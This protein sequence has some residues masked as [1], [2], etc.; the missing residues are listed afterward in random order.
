MNYSML[1]LVLAYE[2]L[3]I[4][5]VGAFL[6]WRQSK[7]A[8]EK[9]GFAL[10]GRHLPVPAVATTMALTVLGSALYIGGRVAYAPLY[11]AGV[12]Y[13]RSGAWGVAVTG[14]MIVGYEVIRALF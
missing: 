11:L 2:I 3:L 4:G 8:P 12:P 13:L 6:A 1:L 9:D 7:S 5:G 10:A 14:I